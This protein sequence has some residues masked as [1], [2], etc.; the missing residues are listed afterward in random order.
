MTAG[1]VHPLRRDRELVPGSPGWAYQVKPGKVF[2]VEETRPPK[3]T[4][5]K[6]EEPAQAA[7]TK[8]EFRT[9]LEWC[10][11]VTRGLITLRPNG[12]VDTWYYRVTV[13]DQQATISH[14]ELMAGDAWRERFRAPGLGFR[15]WRE[16]LTNIVLDQ[17]ERLPLTLAVTRTGWHTVGDDQVYVS[18]DGRARPSGPEV[19]VVGAPPELEA[20]AGPVEL[21][22]GHTV[23]DVL[24]QVVKNAGWAPVFGIGVGARSLGQTLRPVPAALLAVGDQNSGKTMFGYAGR[25]LVMTPLAGDGTVK[26]PPPVTAKMSEDTV[27]DIEAKIDFEADMPSLLDDLALT[28]DA[29]VL[30]QRD[31]VAKLE[32]IIRA[33]GNGG[34]MRGRRK[35]DGI[36]P[37][38]VRA[39]RTI[40]VLTAQSLPPQMQAS[41]YRRAVVLSLVP[42]DCNWRW[43]K[44]INTITDDGPGDMARVI[45]PGL[46]AIGDRII[47]RLADAEDPAALLTD[48]D[49]TGRAV[50][51]EHADREIPGWAD[52]ETGMVGVVEMAGAMLGGLALVADAA[53]VERRA[54]LDVVASPLARSLAV[55]GDTMEDRR[56]ATDDLKTAIGDVIRHGFLSRRAFLTGPDGTTGTTYLPAGLTA[57]AAGLRQIGMAE[58]EG[59]GVAFHY[60][61]AYGG[62]AVRPSALYDLARASGDGRTAGYTATSIGKALRRAGALVPGS[63]R[64]VKRVT[65]NGVQHWYLVIPE[66]V[67]WPDLADDAGDSGPNDAVPHGQDDGGPH[68]TAEQPTKEN[69]ECPTLWTASTSLPATSASGPA[70]NA[71]M[72]GSAGADAETSVTT[73]TTPNPSNKQTSTSPVVPSSSPAGPAAD[74]R[75]GGTARAAIDA[76]PGG[77][78]LAAGAT[79]HGVTWVG[80]AGADVEDG[81]YDSL[82]ALLAAV[83]ERMP[84]GGTIAID[85][86][87]AARL[88]YPDKPVNARPGVQAKTPSKSAKSRQECRAV[89]E[90]AGAGWQPSA[91]G[92][93]AW[94]AWHGPDR[95]S[96]VIVVPE[97]I[98]PRKMRVSGK[99]Y[100]LAHHD[101]LTAAYLLSRYRQLTGVNFVMTSGTSGVNMM[102]DA[103]GPNRERTGRRAR[104]SARMKWDGGDSPASGVQEHACVWDRPLDRLSADERA[105]PYVVGFDAVS[106]F[107]SAMVMAV[108]PWDTLTHTGV[109]VGFDASAPGYWQV[110][111]AWRPFDLLPDLTGR[112]GDG[113]PHWLTTPTVAHLIEHG[114]PEEMI[115]DAW[116]PSV[117][118]DERGRELPRGGRLLH[119]SPGVA[120]KIRDALAAIDPATPDAD[121]AAVRAAIKATFSEGVG[122][123]RHGTAYVRRPDWSDLIIGTARATLLRKVAKVGTET[124]RWPVRINHDCVYYAANST[125]AAREVPTWEENGEIKSWKLPKTGDIPKLGEWTVKPENVLTMPEFLASD[126]RGNPRKA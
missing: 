46:R 80:P 104:R 16:V 81:G 83:S 30:V 119:G 35:R 24:A 2:K 22:E 44:Q 49:A 69:T 19:D 90:A 33:V 57:Q 25:L 89:T 96:I 111:G 116:L 40:P 67:I 60:V 63:A 27:T 118:Q 1:T 87:A 115:T 123:L 75:A 78:V 48:A 125:D 73:A 97:W 124:G 88:G 120:E 101:A 85:A 122:M 51:S 54:L 79:E 26:Y 62:V 114:M 72:S 3:P 11:E 109:P 84:S 32:R 36:T 58:Y 53:G 64:P 37:Q 52:S 17:A 9:V 103:L 8:L 28:L 100:I 34:P 29:P 21:P 12:E 82:P 102:R 50:L 42:G 43:W 105:M 56:E 108:L 86:G 14:R 13:K 68:G 55:Q 70:G 92:I 112:G 5:K 107:L 71:A 117:R 93:G 6:G 31:A 66:T 10:P 59:Q 74:V 121:E 39:V 61:P 65:I 20:A 23:A 4:G 15:T 76:P 113:G 18:A 91:A 98:D 94:T 110:S 77:P 126:V 95:P 99:P 106:Q 45:A 7:P 38:A 47:E 41:L